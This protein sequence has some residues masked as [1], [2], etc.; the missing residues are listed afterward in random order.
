M[1]LGPKQSEEVS[2]KVV[3]CDAMPCA[4]RF[5]AVFSGLHTQNG[6]A[7][8]MRINSN[9][10]VCEKRMKAGKCR[11]SILHPSQP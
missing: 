5:W 11:E 4:I 7:V 2:Y 8:V 6:F 9:A 3:S 10:Y 1:R